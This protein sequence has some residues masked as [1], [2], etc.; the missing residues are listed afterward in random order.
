M[1]I[2]VLAMVGIFGFLFGIAVGVVIATYWFMDRRVW[3]KFWITI[4]KDTTRDVFEMFVVTGTTFLVLYLA[5]DRFLHWSMVNYE[6]YY[7]GMAAGYLVASLILPVL[8]YR[9]IH[10]P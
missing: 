3:K 6:L 5:L 8:R 10:R 7:C 1:E 9:R 4:C 2:V